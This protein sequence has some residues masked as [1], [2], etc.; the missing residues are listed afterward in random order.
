VFESGRQDRAQEEGGRAAV[1]ALAGRKQ[2][3]AISF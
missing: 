2:E 1:L 3:L